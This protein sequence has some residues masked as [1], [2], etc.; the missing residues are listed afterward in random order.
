MFGSR[1]L[2]GVR[3]EHLVELLRAIHRGRLTCPIDHPKL[4]TS[5]FLGIAE[6]LETLRGLDRAGVVAV[7]TA[8]LA[9]RR[10]R[11]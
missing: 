10:A 11:R 3:D 5:G 4:A 1:G 6:H 7:I 8:V 9:E 2:V